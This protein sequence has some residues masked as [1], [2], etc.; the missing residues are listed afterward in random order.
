VCAGALSSTRRTPVF[1]WPLAK[2][3]R[4]S[5]GSVPQQSDDNSL[6]DLRVRVRTEQYLPCQNKTVSKDSHRQVSD[7]L[8][9]LSL[10]LGDSDEFHSYDR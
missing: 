4:I 3:R 6:F 7:T 1:L 8:C 10:S 5:V 9:S 2:T